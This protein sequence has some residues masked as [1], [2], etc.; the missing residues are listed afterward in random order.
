MPF[1]MFLLYTTGRSSNRLHRNFKVRTSTYATCLDPDAP[2]CEVTVTF[3][4]TRTGLVKFC[5]IVVFCVNCEYA[6]IREPNQI[7]SR[8]SGIITIAIFLITGEA[9]LLNRSNILEGTDIL[10]ICFT[11]L[12]ALPSVRSLLP[13][14]PSSYGCLLDILGILPNVRLHFTLR[15][16]NYIDIIFSGHHCHIMYHLFRKFSP[17]HA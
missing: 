13:G 14:V 15:V 4:V 6:S 10:A 17:E 5:V 2:G 9:L 8:L 3:S 16:Q 7:R 11:A 12:F 1:C